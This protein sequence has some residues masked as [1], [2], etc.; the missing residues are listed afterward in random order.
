MNQGVIK[1]I[2]SKKVNKREAKETEN[3]ARPDCHS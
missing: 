1:Y 3:E 2:R